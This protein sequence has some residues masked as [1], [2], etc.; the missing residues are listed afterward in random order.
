MTNVELCDP[1]HH[2][3]IRW[4][5]PGT[6]SL[7]FFWDTPV[8]KFLALILTSVTTPNLWPSQPFHGPAADYLTIPSLLP[9]SLKSLWSIIGYCL[10]SNFILFL[11]DKGLTQTLRL[12]II[13]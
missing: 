7:L 13:L 5:L 2:S 12:C 11:C 8:L 1:D 3:A 6:G 10:Q 4:H 9:A